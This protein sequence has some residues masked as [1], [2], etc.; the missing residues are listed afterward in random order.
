M[1]YYEDGFVAQK[2]KT[3]HR[4]LEKIKFPYHIQIEDNEER[5]ILKQQWFEGK[6]ADYKRLEHQQLS[7]FAFQ[8]L[9]ETNELIN[10]DESGM[11]STYRLK[12]KWTRRFERF[13]DH[14]QE[15]KRLLK[16]SY[17]VLVKHAFNALNS[18]TVLPVHSE[19]QTILHGDVV[20]HNVML[21]GNEVKLIDFDLASIGEASDE[22]VLWL[23]RV[24]PN[25][26]YELQQLMKNHRYL[27]IAQE[28]LQYLQFPNEILRECLFYLKLSDRQKLACYPFIQ[29]IVYEWL[30]HKEAL[31]KQIEILQS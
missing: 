23:H 6:S 5:H 7:L 31:D 20:H 14:E 25:V 29:S 13:V 16:N 8:R 17:G 9:H 2:V 28:K 24:L 4:E 12:E 3:I 11:L 18:M 1:K 21:R 10:W 30:K 27:Q 15:L 19:R 22:I 26:Q